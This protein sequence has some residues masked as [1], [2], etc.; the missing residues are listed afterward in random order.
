MSGILG[1]IP[2]RAGSVGVPGKNVRPLAGR[3]LI[4]HTVEAACYSRLNRVVV[5]TDSEE[6]ATIA[7]AAGAERPFLRPSKLATNSA[8]AIGVVRHALEY[9]QRHESWTPE[10][11]FYLQPTSPF[12]TSADIDKALDMLAAENTVNSIMS[13]STITEHPAF[14]WINQAGHLKPAFPQLVRP[15]LRQDLLPLFIDNNAI[16]LSRTSYLLSDSAV[17][18]PIIDLNN[19]LP[20]MI[21][22]PLALDIDTEMQFRFAD[23]LM[24]DKMGMAT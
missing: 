13:V 16:M 18:L 2:A 12:R 23:F 5:S 6:I 14:Q 7:T 17:D 22:G 20:M 3:P 9:F 11:V 21:D 8:L 15:Q 1:L 10:A 19:F 4:A 24:Q